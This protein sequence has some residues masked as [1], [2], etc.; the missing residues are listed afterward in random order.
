[1]N[2]WF[3]KRFLNRIR[4]SLKSKEN[5]C[6]CNV[7]FKFDL[8]IFLK[9]RCQMFQIKKCLTVSDIEDYQLQWRVPFFV[10]RG[11]KQEQLKK[12]KHNSV[13]S[14]DGNY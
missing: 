12:N 13:D 4:P 11:P 8:M 3:L 9:V 2:I 1:M 10:N 7:G 14:K 6:N 5:A